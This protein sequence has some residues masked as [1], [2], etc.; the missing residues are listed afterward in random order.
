MPLSFWIKPFSEFGLKWVAFAGSVNVVSPCSTL[1]PSLWSSLFY[2][3]NINWLKINYCNFSLLPSHIT[4]SVVQV[5]V[6]HRTYNSR[7]FTV[8]VFSDGWISVVLGE[9]S[10]E[11][12]PFLFWMMAELEE[13]VN[14]YNTTN[15]HHKAF[16]VFFISFKNVFWTLL[17]GFRDNAPS[18]S[19]EDKLQM[20]SKPICLAWW[21]GGPVSVIKSFKKW[22]CLEGETSPLDVTSPTVQWPPAEP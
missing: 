9:E 13:Q 12:K 5:I 11:G 7:I 8:V 15:T 3:Q 19:Q 14:F 17:G 10:E 2:T 16:L 22:F 18:A 4:S 21:C 6:K 20:T 1:T